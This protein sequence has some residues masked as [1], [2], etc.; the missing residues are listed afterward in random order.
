[1][2]VCVFV[3][4]F[5]TNLGSESNG[6]SGMFPAGSLKERVQGESNGHVTDAVT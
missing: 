6:G 3:R 4:I 5:E 1:M 2:C